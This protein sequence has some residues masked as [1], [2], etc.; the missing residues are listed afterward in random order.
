M[1]S[2]VNVDEEN[3]EVFEEE[4]EIMATEILRGKPYS[5]PALKPR[6]NK[7]DSGDEKFEYDFDISKANQIFYNL[8]KDQQ[9]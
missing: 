2:L 1:I 4:V 9:I 7:G 6:K 3:G 8:I 5:C